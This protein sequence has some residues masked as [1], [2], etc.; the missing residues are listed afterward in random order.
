MTTEKSMIQA[1]NHHSL[2]R[3]AA[4]R[5]R[6][7][8]DDLAGALAELSEIDGRDLAAFPQI[9]RTPSAWG[10]RW[11]TVRPD[12]FLALSVCPPREHQKRFPPRAPF[13]NE[14]SAREFPAHGSTGHRSS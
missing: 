13:S 2:V 9:G 6:C 10:P 3:P 4:S 11:T 1:K 8:R 7:A 14:C 5:V 12:A